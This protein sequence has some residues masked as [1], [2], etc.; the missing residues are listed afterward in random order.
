MHY[1]LRKPVTT[2]GRDPR[3]DI[4]LPGDTQVS[5]VHAEIRREGVYFVIYDL[6]STNGTFVNGQR[7]SRQVLKEA[8]EI[9]VGRT[10]LVFQR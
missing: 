2:I 1:Q 10:R 3:S 5:K 9:R 4:P 7:V 8:D 6:N